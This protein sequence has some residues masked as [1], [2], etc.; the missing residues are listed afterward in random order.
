MSELLKAINEQMAGLV[1]RVLPSLVRLSNG[2]LGHGAGTIWHPEGLILTNAHVVQNKAPKV[3]LWDGRTFPSRLLCVDEK[4]DLAAIAIEAV[5][6][7]TIPLGNGKSVRPGQWVVAL[8]HPWGVIG[9]GSAG[10]VIDIGE[11]PELPW[12]PAELIQTELQLR[13]GHSGGPLLD[14]G[15]RLIGINTMI[16]GPQVGLAIPV[17]VVKRFLKDNLGRAGKIQES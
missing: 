15:G 14:A 8:G 2:R 16:A 6:L 4:R 10:I 11:P 5:D 17:H 3:T 9:A 7:P 12:Y 13:P 1:D